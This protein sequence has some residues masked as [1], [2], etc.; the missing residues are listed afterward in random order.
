MRASHACCIQVRPGTR[1]ERQGFI[2][3]SVC[4]PSP[5]PS[6]SCAPRDTQTGGSTALIRRVSACDRSSLYWESVTSQFLLN[7]Q[8]ARSSSPLHLLVPMK[9][10][11][12]HRSFDCSFCLYHAAVIPNPWARSTTL[13]E[14]K[15]TR[16]KTSTFPPLFKWLRCTF[17]PRVLCSRIFK[18]KL[19]CQS[20]EMCMCWSQQKE[21]KCCAGIA[22][23]HYRACLQYSSK[24]QVSTFAV[25]IL[26]TRIIQN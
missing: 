10:A 6:E 11:P 8:D 15:K 2:H 21:I 7:L 24:L 1:G 9:S 5:F 20:A 4:N 23:N 3:I 26:I 19:R 13:R 25:F 14:I 22:R 17:S 12:D 18:W 16:V